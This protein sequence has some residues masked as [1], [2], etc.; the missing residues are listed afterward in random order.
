MEG[1]QKKPQN[2]GG[3]TKYVKK[4]SKED[5]SID[6][7][8]VSLSQS[9]VPITTPQSTKPQASPAASPIIPPAETKPKKSEEEE[10][11]GEPQT[12]FNEEEYKKQFTLPLTYTPDQDP[13]FYSYSHFDIHEEMLKDEVRTKSYMN[14]CLNNKEQF[15]DK[16]V[17]DIGCGTGILSIFAARAGAKHVYGID[18]ANI[19]DFVSSISCYP[20]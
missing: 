2:T 9:P 6:T 3:P 18:N 5:C 20:A 12:W 13:Y 15:K 1:S 16:I 4:E 11:K 10:F 19:V 14:A 7:T 8:E 17:L